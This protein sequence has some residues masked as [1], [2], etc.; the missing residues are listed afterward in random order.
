LSTRKLQSYE[1]ARFQF[2]WPRSSQVAAQSE[3]ELLLACPNDIRLKQF[4]KNQFTWKIRWTSV[5]FTERTRR[6]RRPQISAPGQLIPQ[7]SYN[8]PYRAAAIIPV[9]KIPESVSRYRTYCC[10]S[11][12]LYLSKYFVI[13]IRRELLQLSAK[14]VRL[15]DKLMHS[16]HRLTPRSLH[17]V[18]A[19][20]TPSTLLQNLHRRRLCRGNRELRPA[21]HR[22]TRANIML[23]SRHL[24]GPIFWFWKW[25][26][27]NRINRFHKM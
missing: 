10:H 7:N 16:C 26:C 18:S 1:F 22:G 2:L 24:S 25:K 12:T 23:C 17:T 8:F 20:Y 27:N 13:R 19:A 14:F 5:L 9:K 11:E 15:S 6:T 4:R 3:P 21:T